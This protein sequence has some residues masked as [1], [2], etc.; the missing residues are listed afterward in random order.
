MAEMVKYEAE[1]L[2]C[3]AG[4]DVPGLSWGAAMS[5]ALESLRGKRLV[6]MVGNRAQITDKG[7]AALAARKGGAE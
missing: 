5:V 2:R 3:I 4:E 6:R 1:V 7:K